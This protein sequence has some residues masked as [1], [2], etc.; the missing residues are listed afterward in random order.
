MFRL[1]LPAALALLPLAAGAT[2]PRADDPAASVPET[3]YRTPP[4]YRPAERLS[5]APDRHW[6]EANRSVAGYHPMTLTMPE[7]APARPPGQP[8]AAPAPAPAH[9]H[10]AHEHAAHG[11]QAVK[12]QH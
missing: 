11:A 4:V 1:L 9:E 10:G 7:R 12:G 2:P 6:V 5:T 3:P 8:H